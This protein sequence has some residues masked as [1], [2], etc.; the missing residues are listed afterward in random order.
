MAIE[1]MSQNLK[2]KYQ[3]ERGVWTYGEQLPYGLT[4]EFNLVY[5]RVDGN[6]T[7]DSRYTKWVDKSKGQ[8]RAWNV[9]EDGVTEDKES[10]TSIGREPLVQILVKNDKGEVVWMVI[11]LSRLP[12]N[13]LR[14][15]QTQLLI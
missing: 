6:N 9:K 12:T 10:A 3:Y 7:V 2:K 5:Y 14:I 1:Y 4:Y 8:I 11:F 15:S 13:L